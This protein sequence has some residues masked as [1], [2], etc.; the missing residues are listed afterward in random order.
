MYIPTSEEVLARPELPE[1]YDAKYVKPDGD[2]ETNAFPDKFGVYWYP[3]LYKSQPHK[4]RRW[5][6]LRGQ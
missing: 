2:W 6:K 4:R 5:F 3:V 1:D